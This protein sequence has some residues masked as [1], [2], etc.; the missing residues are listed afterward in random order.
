MTP[1]DLDS[2]LGKLFF[3]SRMV[4]QGRTCLWRLV[5]LRSRVSRTICTFRVDDGAY[6]NILWWQHFLSRSNGSSLILETDWTSAAE[7]DFHA[8][9]SGTLGFGAVFGLAWFSSVWCAPSSGWSI[10]TK[11]LYPIFLAYLVWEPQ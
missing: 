7:L 11:K 8:N 1:R 2:L 9:A 4:C 10:F 3:A 6:A 5:D